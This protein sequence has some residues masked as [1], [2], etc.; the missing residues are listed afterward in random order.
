VTT[1]TID[2]FVA[3]TVQLYEQEQEEPFGSPLPGL[4]V[5]RWFGWLFV[6]VRLRT[7]KANVVPSDVMPKWCVSDRRSVL[8]RRLVTK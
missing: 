2:R 5:K 8:V 7:K 4:Y 6:G 1:K 3:R